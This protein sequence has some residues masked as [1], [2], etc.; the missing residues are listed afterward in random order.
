[1]PYIDLKTT[2][3][4]NAQQ[5]NA[6]KAAFGKAIECFPGKTESWLMVSIDS[7]KKMWFRGDNSADSAMIDVSLL[8]SVDKSAS[9][10]MTKELCSVMASQLGISPDRV[11]VKYS[12]YSHWG[13][14]NGNF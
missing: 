2:V 14:N 9:E 6:V 4:M 3:N 10:K 5:E 8:G 12:G 11:Y 7:G 1:M 13:W